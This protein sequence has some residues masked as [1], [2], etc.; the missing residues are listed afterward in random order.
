MTST[1]LKEYTFL[2]EKTGLKEQSDF[3][4]DGMDC[5]YCVSP[6]KRVKYILV[7]E[8][9][10][11]LLRLIKDEKRFSRFNRE[12]YLHDLKSKGNFSEVYIIYIPTGNT[13]NVPV[14]K[15]EANKTY[16]RKY[17]FFTREAI[18]FINGVRIDDDNSL[19]SGQNPLHVWADILGKVGL[20]GCLSELFF[21]KSITAYL[22]GSDFNSD[23]LFE[24]SYELEEDIPF[25]SIKWVKSLDTAGFRSFCFND[26]KLDFGQVNLFYG[27]NGSGKSSVLEAIEYALTSEIGRMSDFKVTDSKSQY[28]N[29]AAYTK[30]ASVIRLCPQEA[31]KNTKLIERSWYGVPISRSKSTLNSNFA[32]FN[33]FDSEAAYNFVHNT[34][35]STT[36]FAA[37]FGNLMFGEKVIDSEKKW[38]RFY[39]AFQSAFTEIEKQIDNAVDELSYYKKL[40]KDTSAEGF[41]K[42]LES[43]IK[44]TGYKPAA[45][46]P[47]EVISRYTA[48][49]KDLSA[50]C[51]VVRPINSLDLFSDKSFSE[52]RSLISSEK[53]RNRELIKK[54][55]EIDKTIEQYGLSVHALAE[56]KVLL[57]KEQAEASEE[58]YALLKS[59]VGW[60]DAQRILEN[61][62]KLDL[63]DDLYDRKFSLER[64]IKGIT[65]LK[66]NKI[67]SSFFAK[68]YFNE[69][70]EGELRVVRQN[71]EQ[72]KKELSKLE[73]YINK[74]KARMSSHEAEFIEIRRLGKLLAIGSKCPLCGYDYSSQSELLSL[75]DKANTQEPELEKALQR[76]VECQRDIKKYDDILSFNA[77]R[78]AAIEQIEEIEDAIPD[79]QRFHLNLASIHQFINSEEDLRKELLGVEARIAT[80]EMEGFSLSKVFDAKNYKSDNPLYLEYSKISGNKPDYSKW[81]R[82]RVEKATKKNEKIQHDLEELEK[83]KSSI[84]ESIQIKCL[85]KEKIELKLKNIPIQDCYTAEAAIKD[86]EK[87]FQ[88]DPSE[89]VFDWIQRIQLFKRKVSAEVDRLRNDTTYGKAKSEI[90]RL[91]ELLDSLN[92]QRG[93]AI[94]ALEAFQKMPTLSSFVEESIRGNIERISKYFKWMHHS[95]EFQSLDVDSDGIFAI[96]GMNKQK[97]RIYEMS[98]GQRAAMAMS[99]MLAFH[100]AATTVPEFLLLDEPLA[101]MDDI[102]VMNT[103]D[104]LKVLVKNGTQ[105]FFTTANEEMIRLFKNTFA[106]TDYDYKEFEFVKRINNT[107]VINE[108]SVNNAPS[109]E[110]LTM[111]DIKLDFSQFNEIRRI[112]ANNQKRLT[113]K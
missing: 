58:Y 24:E 1:A 22:N 84:D 97:V 55:E 63:L 41:S 53:R 110:E 88:P 104:I 107:S 78:E 69:I 76:L 82:A 6:D 91:S 37:A 27:A 31:R 17:V 49:S 80:L 70:K 109:L 59:E 36:S 64:D 111:D 92:A 68:K 50:V 33:S 35:S 16:A 61:K 56:Q 89:N 11:K 10:N 71:R 99:V 18:T 23:S 14:Q 83:Q 15:I 32:R 26:T 102:Q 52:T 28:P 65:T 3:S 93:R 72:I 67:I 9:E 57:L 100:T 4:I 62:S 87:Y 108:R 60:Y 101:T 77:L 43:L 46:L 75:I 7:Y 79:I 90:V 42:E 86:V 47:N 29:V 21:S 96:R 98:T 39:T 45:K 19:L 48:L 34:D 8:S 103:L 40:F 44:K 85:E 2:L 95:G 81:I 66:E 13:T 54:R 51:E 113:K 106:N 25:P 105:I 12:V 30:E 112:L 5:R 94:N 73:E 20:T 74:R 38:R